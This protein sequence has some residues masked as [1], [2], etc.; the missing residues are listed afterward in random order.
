MGFMMNNFMMDSDSD[1]ELAHIE[2]AGEE[3]MQEV[4]DVCVSDTPDMEEEQHLQQ[5]EVKEPLIIH[6]NI[7]L[8]VT[9]FPTVT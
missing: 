5:T 9:L 7:N 2:P 3:E 1:P 8:C 4:K 6:L